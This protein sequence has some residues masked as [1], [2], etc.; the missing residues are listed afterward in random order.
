MPAS[1]RDLSRSRRPGVAS[2]VDWDQLENILERF[3]ADWRRGAQPALDD[4]LPEG[5]PERAA[6]LIELVHEDLEYRVAAGG[7]AR[8][9]TYVARYPELATDPAV[10]QDLIVTEFRSRRRRGDNC[11]V[12]EFLERFPDHADA[13]SS[14]LQEVEMVREEPGRKRSDDSIAW[15]RI[16]DCETQGAVGRGGMGVW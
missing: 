5:G 2:A 8:V 11:D 16:A 4:Y 9:E 3:E 7:A 14:R 6:L 12:A 13:L 1:K 10:L 15:P